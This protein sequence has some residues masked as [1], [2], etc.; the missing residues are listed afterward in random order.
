M[1][2]LAF[3]CG[4]GFEHR[5]CLLLV[6][7]EDPQSVLEFPQIRRVQMWA[8]PTVVA[9]GNLVHSLDD[10]LVKPTSCDHIGS[11]ASCSCELCSLNSLEGAI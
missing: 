2:S 1:S 3:A 7:P 9:R 5:S 6:V 11:Y 8:L 10:S 4:S